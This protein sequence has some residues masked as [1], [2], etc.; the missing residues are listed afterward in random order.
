[1]DVWL[2]APCV[3]KDLSMFGWEN[4]FCSAQ[5]TRVRPGARR[6][7]GD[8]GGVFAILPDELSFLWTNNRIYLL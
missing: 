2:G 6:T 3:A 8:I 5:E 4:P 7:V 1:M